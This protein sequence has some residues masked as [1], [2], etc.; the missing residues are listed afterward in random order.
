MRSNESV[1]KLGYVR[2]CVDLLKTIIIGASGHN[3]PA[4]VGANILLLSVLPGHFNCS[5]RLHQS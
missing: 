4:N 5:A 2:T 3:G 1:T